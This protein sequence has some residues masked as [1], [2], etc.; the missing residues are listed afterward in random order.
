MKMTHLCALSRTLTSYSKYYL[1]ILVDKFNNMTHVVMV[2][3]NLLD[4]M[5]VMVM[6]NLLNN[7]FVM[8][9]AN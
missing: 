9:T 5:F 6:V 2:M 7:M 1:S 4:N 8:I 3:V